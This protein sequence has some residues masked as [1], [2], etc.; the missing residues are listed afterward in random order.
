MTQNVHARPEFN[1]ALDAYHRVELKMWLRRQQSRHFTS[2][3]VHVQCMVALQYADR[4][5]PTVR[6]LW[7]LLHHIIEKDARLDKRGS[8]AVGHRLPSYDTFRKRIADL[9]RHYVL[10]ARLGNDHPSVAALTIRLD[11]IACMEANL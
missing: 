7:H 11:I 8:V 1:A 5:R 6:Q 3:E 10:K 4:S 9:P 2:S